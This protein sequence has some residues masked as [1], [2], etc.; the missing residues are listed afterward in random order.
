[1]ASP[2][3]SLIAVLVIRE[4]SRLSSH[5]KTLERVSEEPY[6]AK[7][8][9]WL[10]RLRET[11]TTGLTHEKGLPHLLKALDDLICAYESRAPDVK[12]LAYELIFQLGIYRKG[13]W[14]YL[15]W[16]V[17]G[18]Q[19]CLDDFG[20][21]LPR[22]R[23]AFKMRYELEGNMPVGEQTRLLKAQYARLER[24]PVQN[25]G[26]ASVKPRRKAIPAAGKK[27]GLASRLFGMLFQRKGGTD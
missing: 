3:P 21:V 17:P 25:R 27:P 16:T 11:W 19:N 5:V 12:T 13:H 6:S 14:A 26:K 18:I 8:A 24:A 10:A 9:V 4:H 22:Y 1:M 7:N 2:S 23:D 20:A 15:R